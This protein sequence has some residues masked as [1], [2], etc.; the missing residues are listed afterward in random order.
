MARSISVAATAAAAAVATEP[1]HARMSPTEYQIRIQIALKGQS[2]Q[3]FI[4][5]FCVGLGRYTFDDEDKNRMCQMHTH[6]HRFE[7][8]FF[9]Y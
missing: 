6:S 8:V 9:L 7:R 1:L 5:F 3:K 2:N 4:M